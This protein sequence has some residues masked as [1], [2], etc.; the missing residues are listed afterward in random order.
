MRSYSSDELKG[1]VRRLYKDRLRSEYRVS[2]AHEIDD[3]EGE[4]EKSEGENELLEVGKRLYAEKSQKILKPMATSK[5]CKTETAAPPCSECDL[6]CFSVR[7][8]AGGEHVHGSKRIPGHDR[9]HG[10]RHSGRGGSVEAEE[11]A[12]AATLLGGRRAPS[13][14]GG[15]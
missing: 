2:Y 3:D 1:L 11:V 5:K 10:I 12:A 7:I 6:S 14:G 8:H 9:S 15:V 13:A 4:G